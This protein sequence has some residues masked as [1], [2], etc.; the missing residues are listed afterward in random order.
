MTKKV[1][2]ENLFKAILALKNSKEVE[3]FLKDLTTPQELEN[4]TERFEV[5]KRLA[6]SKTQRE[7]SKDTKVALVTVTRVNKFLKNGFN[8]YK[9]IIDRLHHHPQ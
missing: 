2:Y 8:G 6:E 4:F 5:A 9:L 1:Q 7:V 3:A